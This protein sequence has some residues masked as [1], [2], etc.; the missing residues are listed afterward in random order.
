M[1]DDLRRS[2]PGATVHLASLASLEPAVCGHPTTPQLVDPNKE[3]VTEKRG[4]TVN[5]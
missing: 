1:V 2:A 3:S 4:T 5:P